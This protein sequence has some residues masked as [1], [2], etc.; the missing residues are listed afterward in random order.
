MTSRSS[1]ESAGFGTLANGCAE[2]RLDPGFV[3]R[4]GPTRRPFPGGSRRGRRETARLPPLS[5]A[6]RSYAGRTADELSQKAKR[7]TPSARRVLAEMP[8][9]RG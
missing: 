5:G 6:L 7:V 9:C 1:S 3:A 2:I 8:Y 4:P